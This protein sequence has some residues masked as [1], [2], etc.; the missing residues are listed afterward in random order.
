MKICR[1]QNACA[2]GCIVALY[3]LLHI[4]NIGCPIRFFTGIS[5]AGCGMTRAWLSVLKL[6]FAEAFRF[7][8]LFWTI[9]PGGIFFIFRKRIPKKAAHF[10]MGGLIIL[11]ITVYIVRM[12]NPADTV[13]KIDFCNSIIW[14]ILEKMREILSCL[15][16]IEV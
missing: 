16:R 8:P 9:P 6:D 2:M 10:I 14:K 11:F 7:H 4:V 3:I 1:N 5:C 15:I 12:L 13:V